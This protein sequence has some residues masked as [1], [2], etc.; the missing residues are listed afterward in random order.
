MPITMTNHAPGM[1][2]EAYDQVMI[3]TAEPLRS[4]PG[5]I[6]H[7]AQITPDGVTV[8]EVWESR[9]QWQQWFD[10][11][12]RPHLPAGAAEPTVVDLHNAVAR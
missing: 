4:S 12:V 10:A 11:S 9:E 6:S 5:F 7:T 8:T 1:T 2:A 3:H